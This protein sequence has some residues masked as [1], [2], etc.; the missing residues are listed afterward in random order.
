M[1]KDMLDLC[2]WVVKTAKAA[3]ADACAVSLDASRNVSVSYRNRKPE[4]I[5][6]ASTKALSVQ[7]FAS[8]RY[9][10]QSTSDLRREALR[11]F[12]GNAV[13]ATRLLAEDPLRSLPDPKY[14]EGRTAADLELFDSGYAAFTPEARHEMARALED[15]CLQAGG[16][17]VVSVTS[18]VQDGSQE[19]VLMTSNG[20]A[21]SA[22]GTYYAP[23]VQMTAQD[24]G[25]RRPNGFSYAVAVQRADLPAPESIGADAA[26]RTLELLGAKKIK[27]ET[28][29][30]IVEN[31]NVGRLLSGFA[32]ALNGRSIQ[33]KRS[34]L[35]DKKGQAVASPQ[36]TVI[37]DPFVPR[38]LGSRHFDGD[39][40]AARRRVIV[41]AGV[42][43]EFYVDWYYSRKLGCEPTSGSISNLV[44]PPGTRSLQEI[45]KD[46]GRGILVT[47]FIGGNA[48]STTGDT[49]IGIIGTLF[50]NGEPV[51]PVCEMNIA[52]NYLKL[53]PRCIEVANDPFPYSAN[54][55]PS[56]VFDKVVV[57][58]L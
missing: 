15:A 6:E 43:R 46:L 17:K 36:L 14:Y 57:S 42:L 2:E 7:V 51:Q 48:N 55:F 8:G 3:G 24:E 1:N 21:G 18:T 23:N 9:S 50:A 33:Q 41:E 22:R 52:D 56:L 40:L 34:F 30:V 39:G 32:A 16:A 47:G 53:L 45:M 5:K 20:M 49:S 19:S 13:A 4:T 58:G 28:L 10:V 26:R 31:Q 37:D 54:R 25:D 38:G 11:G 29:P 35:A 27:T 44:V 12:L